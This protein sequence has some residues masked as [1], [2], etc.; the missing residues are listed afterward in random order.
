MP[1]LSLRCV[2]NN[3]ERCE[4][5]GRDAWERHAW[6]VVEVLTRLQENR[7]RVTA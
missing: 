4:R 3:R 1:R 5:H 6:D 7:N 2:C